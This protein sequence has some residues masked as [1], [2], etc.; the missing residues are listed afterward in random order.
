VANVDFAVKSHQTF[1]MDLAKNVGFQM[2][3]VIDN[4]NAVLGENA[5]KFNELEA[6]VAQ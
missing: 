5:K 1:T 3:T 6:R 4:Q 2:H